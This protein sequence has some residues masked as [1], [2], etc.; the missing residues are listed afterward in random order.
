MSGALAREQRRRLT[1]HVTQALAVLMV[2]ATLISLATGSSPF[3]VFAWVGGGGAAGWAAVW[4]AGRRQRAE[5]SDPGD[6]PE[7]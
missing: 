1:T 6:R 7:S 2:I 3:R 4:A 5:M